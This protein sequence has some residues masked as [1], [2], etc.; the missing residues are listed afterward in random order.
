M[1]MRMADADVLPFEFNDLA[2]TIRMYLGEVKKL[3]SGMR[4]QVNEQNEE[5]KDGVYQALADPTK[6]FVPPS[7]ELLPSYLN[8]APLDQASD[9]LTTAAAEYEKAFTENGGKASPELNEEL[10]QSERALIDPDGLPNRP[11][12]ENMIYAPG[13]YT[14]YGVKTLPAVREAIEEK[15]WKI[16]DTE[17]AR[18]A[19]AIER[20]SNTLHQAA[21]TISGKGNSN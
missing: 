14:G 9:D 2:D 6:K 21:L 5:I 3:A 16:A 15:Q 7:I 8:F 18:T 4:D 13:F 12:Y 10:I 1:V 19:A 11:W 20:Y 17:I